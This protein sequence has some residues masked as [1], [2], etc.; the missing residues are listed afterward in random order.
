MSLAFVSLST[1]P[2][3][4]DGNWYYYFQSKEDTKLSKIEEDMK[5]CAP[6]EWDEK[7]D[8]EYIVSPKWITRNNDVSAYEAYVIGGVCDISILSE[9]MYKDPNNK[10]RKFDDGWLVVRPRN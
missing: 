1:V 4:A 7:S 2:A 8:S 3:F 6:D 5:V 9:S 10:L